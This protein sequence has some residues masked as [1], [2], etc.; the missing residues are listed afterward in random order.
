MLTENC[1][2][3]FNGAWP[4]ADSLDFQEMCTCSL[5]GIPAV[6]QFKYFISSCGGVL[7]RGHPLPPGF[8]IETVS[9]EG[10]FCDTVQVP[11]NGGDMELI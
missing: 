9:P 6:F 2:P 5:F 4:S 11:S 1:L 7:D 3:W 8:N 10:I